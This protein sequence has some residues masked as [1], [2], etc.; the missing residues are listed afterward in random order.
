MAEADVELDLVDAVGGLG[1]DLAPAVEADVVEVVADDGLV[2]GCGDA[3]LLGLLAAPAVGIGE[4]DGGDGEG[5]DG[6]GDGNSGRGEVDGERGESIK[7]KIR[8]KGR[9]RR[10]DKKNE[11]RKKKL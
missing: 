6:G 5:G 2:V 8:R 1:V 10:N 4:G 11:R 7:K 3:E 9:R